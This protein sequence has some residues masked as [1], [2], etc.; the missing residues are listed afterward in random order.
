MKGQGYD[1]KTK[2]SDKPEGGV[3]VKPQKKIESPKKFG[4]EKSSKGPRN[5]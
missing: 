2:L 4:S 5:T 3:I 1:Q